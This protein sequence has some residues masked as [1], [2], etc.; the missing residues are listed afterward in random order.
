MPRS[1]HRSSTTGVTRSDKR[2]RTWRAPAWQCAQSERNSEVSV[3]AVS[4]TLQ[5]ILAAA[6]ARHASLVP[7]TSG[8]LALT[9]CDAVARVPLE[10]REDAITLTVDGALSIGGAATTTDEEA[11]R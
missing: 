7:E 4:V 6:S 9:A 10:L 5:E 11:A 1:P 8:Y 2:R 3:K